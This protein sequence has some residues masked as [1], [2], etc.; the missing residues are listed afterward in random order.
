MR[1]GRGERLVK[2][3][4]NR[5]YRHLQLS[6]VRDRQASRRTRRSSGLVMLSAR[7]SGNGWQRPPSHAPHELYG[8]MCL[9]VQITDAAFFNDDR[10]P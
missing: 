8:L 1:L 10:G 9:Q 3:P 6:A 7:I 5:F 2:K 4:I